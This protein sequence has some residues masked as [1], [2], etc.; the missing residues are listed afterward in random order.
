M[1]LRASGEEIR[2]FKVAYFAASCDSAETNKEFA[3]SLDLDY[4]ILSD[5]DRRTAEAYGV[6][7]QRIMASR[8]TFYIGKDGDILFIDREVKAGSHGGDIAA[9]LEELGVERN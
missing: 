9:R 3:D 4:P 7:S 6:L 2:K 1:S 5:P 8:W